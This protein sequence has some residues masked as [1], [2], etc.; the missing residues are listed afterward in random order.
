MP[1]TGKHG[2][3]V[4]D[5][6]KA[7]LGTIY[8]QDN[9]ES[10]Q[11]LTTADGGLWDGVNDYTDIT[12]QTSIVKNGSYAMQIHYH[13]LSIDYNRYTTWRSKLHGF[14]TGIQHYFQSAWVRWA[15][16]I[17]NPT[18]AMQRKLFYV[19]T[20]ATA[21]KNFVITFDTSLNTNTG[22]MRIHYNDGTTPFDCYGGDGSSC[23]S[24]HPT[25]WKVNGAAVT[26]SFDTWHHIETEMEA[27]TPGVADGV[28]RVW[29]DGTLAYEMTDA[30]MFVSGTTDFY[31]GI[32]F[33][34]ASDS[35]TPYDEYRHFDDVKISNYRVGP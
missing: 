14:S 9:F 19:D 10:G 17:T 32:R 29:V 22:P 23:R 7:S 12:A 3:R 18:T 16:P 8:F 26:F 25:Y 28:I 11:I 30:A 31:D 1:V 21:T 13:K 34:D 33:G 20:T 4:F 27:N 6:L 35:S 24:V 2:V 5:D 15:T